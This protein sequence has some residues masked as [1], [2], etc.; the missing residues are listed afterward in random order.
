MPQQRFPTDPDEAR[1]AIINAARTLVESSVLSRSQHGNIS[2]RLDGDRFVLTGRGSMVGIE[3][4]ELPIL[5]LSGELVEG[6][7]DPTSREI[8]QMH[9]AIYRKRDDVGAVIHTHS[10]HVTAFALAGKPIEP[11]YEAMVRF[12][13]SDGVP[14]ARYGPRGS[15]QSVSNIVDVV[16]P[17]T[18]A[19]LLENHGLLAFGKDVESTVHS[20]VILEESAEII[21][22]ADAAG[23][24]K[25]IP[26]EMIEA[27]QSRRDQFASMGHGAA[28]DGD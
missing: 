18:Q 12:G 7:I 8:I 11:A 28:T 21:L 5:D 15:D 10:P 17:E 6:T 23:G 26:R 9:A 16:G 1:R 22:K 13:F 19:V 2:A 14:L 24:A 3:P 20:I 4:S 27:T 25:R